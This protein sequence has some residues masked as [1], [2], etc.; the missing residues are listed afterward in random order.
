MART[1]TITSAQRKKGIA[2]W[3]ACDVAHSAIFQ[4]AQNTPWSEAYRIAPDNLR[5]A[6]HEASNALRSF[7]RELVNEGRGWIDDRGYFAETGRYGS[8]WL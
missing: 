2:L 1:K 3:N 8:P 7:E 6:Y 4:G 5:N